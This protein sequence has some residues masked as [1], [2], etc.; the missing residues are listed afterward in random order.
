[1][2]SSR[3]FRKSHRHSGNE[4]EDE[5]D[6]EEED[7]E[8]AEAEEEGEGREAQE[9]ANKVE[10]KGLQLAQMAMSAGFRLDLADEGTSEKHD[11]SGWVLVLC[12]TFQMYAMLPLTDNNVEAVVRNGLKDTELVGWP[13]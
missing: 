9:D 1:M 10:E 7:D 5:E 2:G 13:L 11:C 6:E 3:P 4:A 12:S 8:E